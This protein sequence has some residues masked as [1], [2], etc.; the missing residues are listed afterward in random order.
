MELCQVLPDVTEK[1]QMKLK[2]G[3]LWFSV[4]FSLISLSDS[5]ASLSKLGLCKVPLPRKE[6]SFKVPPAQTSLGF[7]N[8]MD[9]TGDAGEELEGTDLCRGCGSI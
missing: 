8:H 4:H 6:M 2:Y 9:T 3:T 5:S 1:F 7:H